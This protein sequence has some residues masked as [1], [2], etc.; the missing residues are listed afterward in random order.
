MVRAVAFDLKAFRPRSFL[1]VC[2]P[3]AG[4][5][6]PQLSAYGSSRRTRWPG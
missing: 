4:Q 6:V 3:E 5:G 2:L 1:W